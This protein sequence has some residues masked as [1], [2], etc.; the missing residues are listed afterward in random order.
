MLVISSVNV[1]VQEAVLVEV[2]AART[3]TP[4]VLD[5][6]VQ[7]DQRGFKVLAHCNEH[8]SVNEQHQWRE[9]RCCFRCSF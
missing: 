8:D 6:I 9:V 3:F 2:Y 4:R 7:V 1:S 5:C